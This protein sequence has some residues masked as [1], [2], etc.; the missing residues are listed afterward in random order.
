MLD[1]LL[2]ANRGEIAVR[3]LRTARVLG[4]RTVA[5]YSDADAAAPHVRL[6]DEAVRLGP[7]PAADSYL[8]GDAV[9]EAALATGAGAVHPGYGFLAE[10]A[11]FATAVEAA[12]LV[13]VGPTPGQLTVFG[14][15]HR[16]R[17]AARAAGVPLVAG[18]GLLA[19]VDAALAAAEAVGYPVML[20]AVGGGGGIGM[21]A[22]DGPDDLRAAF[23]RVRRV[24][25]AG[26]GNDAVLLERYVRRARHV[27]VQVFGDG[28]GR[29]VSLGDRDCSLQRRHQKVVEEAPAPGLPDDVRERLAASARALTGS[30]AYR[31]AGTVEFV[32]DVDTHDVSFLEV[33]TR[34]QVEHTVTEEVTGI[35]LVGWML[36]LARGDADL[37]AELAALP[38]DGPPL[39]GHAVEA[40]VYAEDPRRGH[41]P[42]AGL[43]THV[44]YPPGVRVDG[45]AEAGQEVTT[46]Y[47]PLLAKVVVHAADRTAALDAAAVA[48]AAT[49]LVGV[50]TNLPQLRAA[51]ADDDVRAAA[52][53]TGTLAGVVDDEPW[54]EVLRPGVMTTVQDWPGRLGHWDV[55]VPPSGPMDDLSFRLGNVA[56]GN[57]EGAPGLEC[58][59]TGP[60]LRFSH[61]ATVCVTGAAAPVTLDGAT[62]PQWE[63]VAVPAGGVLDVGT[64]CGAGLRTYV[65]VRGG[66]DVPRYLGSA[67]TFALGGFGG[68]T[69]QALVTGDVLV[70]A[71]VSD[72]A[73][74]PAPSA[75]P[76]EA[77]P[78]LVHA[79][80]VAVQEGP[81][82]APTYFTRDDMAMLTG[83]TWHVQ[84]HANRTGVR[85]TGPRPRWARPDGGEAGLHPSNLHD[86]PYS[87]GALNV[88]GDTPILLG[89][90][91]PSLGGFACPLTVVVGHRWKLGQLRPGDTVR[92]VP[93]PAATADVLRASTVR[94]AAA[95]V[96]PDLATG[97]DGDDG[98]LARVAGDPA[99]PLGRPDVV[100]LRGAD[101]NVLV[102]YGP[103]VLDLGL[104]MRVH[105]LGE[106]LRARAL[107]GVV[108]VTP[109]VRS[110]HVHVDPALLPVPALVDVLVAIEADLP[111]TTDLE[112][113]SRRVHLPLSFDDPAV[114]EA[115]ARYAVGV[116]PQA[117]WLPSNVEFVRRVNGLA[118]GDDVL[119]TMT[120][121][122]YLVLGLGDVYLGAPLAVPL[123]P[124]H[125]LMTTKYNP[126]RTWTASG[127][128]GLGGQYLCV[129]G[130]DSPGGYQLVGRTLPVWSGHRQHGAFEAGVPWLL[131]FFDRIV[132]HPVGAAELAEQ[133]AAFAAGRLDVRVEHGTF[134]YRDHLE[135]LAEHTDAIAAFRARQADAFA[136][137]RAA[138]AA[139]G[140]LDTVADAPAP[141]AVEPSAP[142]ELDAGHVLVEA[143]MV[144]SVWR[145]EAAAGADVRAGDPLVALEAMKLELAVAAPSDGRVVQ[146]LVEPGQ[147]V[148]PGAPLAVLAVDA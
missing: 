54:V 5:V 31:S 68:Y 113:P 29:V 6:A 128:V 109:G 2:V 78:A 67:A 121:A 146:V 112:V 140:E 61:A 145:V 80:E 82:P 103:M 87:V 147:Q 41:R 1:T 92:L 91:G 13:F 66:L 12:G 19:D 45:W 97:T 79:W 11:A 124:R 114:A 28:A 115:V 142:V 8:R 44:A 116:R 27:E 89:P 20:K 108:D 43:L 53:T 16:A 64:P 93:V 129:Y 17:E 40:R 106:A 73:P 72:D 58:T 7:A 26:F 4:M 32:Y 88:S 133:R 34:L 141:A 21:Q 57:P 24:A 46:H 90:D 84:A 110:L 111:A 52:H 38:L 49:E 117:P 96:P 74:A 102:E 122:E 63:P 85:L 105:A 119:A 132:W 55:G 144:A 134:R 100:Y 62:V 22:C 15:K 107:P 56:L 120:R 71:P 25:R 98:V 137:E 86:N 135:L 139:A 136:A 126:A 148:G 50:A 123:D 59:L 94:R 77:R 9:L 65:L 36:R 125:R 10:D 23:D 75:V 69:G 127:T 131:R 95:V 60:R 118:S 42:G 51:V 143:P 33:N 37:R 101:D 47:D 83:A 30:V 104:R 48:L 130:M 39:R 70:P 138:W 18:S 76:Q 81:Q 14:D 35:D 99:D 3:V